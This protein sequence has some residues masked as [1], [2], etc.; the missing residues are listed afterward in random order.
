LQLTSIAIEKTAQAKFDTQLT[1][2]AL[3]AAPPPAPAAS[4]KPLLSNDAPAPSLD[5]M[6]PVD[7][8]VRA[9]WASPAPPRPEA[10]RAAH[11]SCDLGGASP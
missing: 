9:F 2:V 6:A 5:G 1:S 8:L 11:E 10:G 3:T 7:Q 4:P